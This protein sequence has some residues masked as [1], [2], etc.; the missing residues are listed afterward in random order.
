VFNTG[1]QTVA[2]GANVLFSSNGPLAGGVAH[3]PGTA[4]VTVANGGD[5]LVNFEMTLAAGAL[6][7]TGA[8]AVTLNGVVQTSTTYG[9]AGLITT[10]QIF[11]VVGLAI[12]TIPSGASLTVRNVGATADTLATTVDGATIV[13]ASFR[14]ARLQ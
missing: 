14:L 1:A 5:Y 3:V 13:N 9:Q 7:A 2:S 6:A 4:T 10:G 11:S 12:L 8:Y